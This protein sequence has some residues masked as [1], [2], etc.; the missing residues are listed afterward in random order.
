MTKEK[1]RKKHLEHVQKTWTLER[2]Y[3]RFRNSYMRPELIGRLMPYRPQRVLDLGCGVGIATIFLERGGCECHGVDIVRDLTKIAR[4]RAKKMHTNPSYIVAN[5]EKLPYRDNSFD[6][7]IASSILEHVR[8]YKLVIKEAT[9][10]LKACGLLALCTTNK[11]HPFQRE[12]KLNS[13]LYFPFY[14]WLPKRFKRKIIRFLLEKRPDLLNYTEHPAIHWFT[15]NQLKDLLR[16]KGYHVFEH[17]DTLKQ[18][19]LRG[20]QRLVLPAVKRFKVLRIFF[21]IY[22]PTVTLYAI[23]IP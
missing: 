20:W 8:D 15:Y 13:L 16:K 11:L 2:G 3:A 5:V 12:V 22:A 1:V 14:P 4:I 18:A 23:K 17:I 7:C 6:F 10:V 21:Y 9:R 19:D